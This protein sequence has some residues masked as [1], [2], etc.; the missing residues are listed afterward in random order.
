MLLSW[1]T[2]RR[3]AK[4][5][6]EP[7]AEAWEATLARNVSHWRFLDDDERVRLRDLIQ[8]FVSEKQ[9]EGCGGLA[10]NDEVRVT[11]AAEA[12][13]LL[14]GR[15]H[16]L[17]AD[18]DSILVYPN[19]VMPPERPTGI[20]ERGG[21]VVHARQPIHGEAWQGGPV[22]LVWDAVKR[23]AR[24]ARDGRNVVFHEFAHKIDMLDG[25]AD[26]TPPL[27]DSAACGTWAEVCSAIYLALRN[28]DPRARSVLDPYGATNEA[29]FFAVATES[30]FE[31]SE[32]LARVLPRLYALL[33]EYYQQDPRARMMRAQRND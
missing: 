19:T 29:E 28:E 4:I 3:R 24:D 23:G 18:V 30:F 7:F 33:A 13:I 31:R 20:F 11:I 16:S 6:A 2:E 15:D 27:A 10:M 21:E 8:V 32:K 25:G 22:I 1:L 26:G 14:L 9:W 12:C 5:E 17:Y